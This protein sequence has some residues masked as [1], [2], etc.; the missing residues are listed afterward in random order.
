MF[1]NGQT[2]ERIGVDVTGDGDV[3]RV[4]A[5]SV[6]ARGISVGRVVELEVGRTPA[7]SLTSSVVIPAFNAARLLGATLDSVAAQTR[8]PDEVIV[9]DDGS[10]DDTA[11]VA[12]RHPVVTR[13]IRR[14]NGG[15]CAARNDAIEASRGDVIFLLD[16]DDLWHP[17]HVERLVTVLSDRPTAWSA[18]SR[19]RAFVDPTEAPAPFESQVDDKV[20]EHDS[21]SFVRA[22]TRAMPAQPSFFAFRRRALDVLGPRPYIEGHLGGGEA[23]FLPGLLAALAPVIEH[24]APLGRYRLHRQAVTGD[25][26]DA[27]RGMVPALL[28]LLAASKSSR[29]GFSSRQRRSIR[30]LAAS[31]L[32]RVG[33]RIGGGGDRRLGRRQIRRAAFLGHHKA[34]LHLAASFVPGMERRVWVQHWR[35]EAARRAEGTPFWAPGSD[36]PVAS[37]QVPT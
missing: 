16:A 5:E 26:M 20:L 34:M 11:Q 15:I 21:D 28:D 18:F 33:R 13:V 32:L 12:A 23:I 10:V 3:R 8:R 24:P 35:P 4:A 31:C 22:T 17:L 7:P 29:L 25:E 14:P 19:F 27:A 1:E 6:T 30:R 36:R 9:V 2:D 37:D